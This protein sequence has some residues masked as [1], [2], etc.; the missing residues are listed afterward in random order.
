[1]QPNTNLKKLIC[2]SNSTMKTKNV[3][4]KLIICILWLAKPLTAEAIPIF[5][6]ADL[7]DMLNQSTTNRMLFNRYFGHKNFKS[8][9]RLLNIFGL[10]L[11][12]VYSANIVSPHGE[13]NCTPA[14][15]PE[16]EHLEYLY[17][18][19]K[20]GE[21]VLVQGTINGV[22]F[23]T[24]MLTP[25]QVWRLPSS[26]DLIPDA[27][28]G[29]PQAQYQLGEVYTYGVGLP[30]DIKLGTEW[31]ERAAKQ[32]HAQATVALKMLSERQ[33]LGVYKAEQD[34]LAD[35]ARQEK[36]RIAAYAAA[37]VDQLY[38]TVNDGDS[39]AQMNL[40]QRYLGG[41]GV[42][43]NESL[44]ID[45]LS[46]AVSQG[47]TRALVA[48]KYAATPG[49]MFNGNAEA[50]FVLGHL[51]AAGQGVIASDEQA[52]E[53]FNLAAKQNYPGAKDAV[54]LY[55]TKVF[56]TLTK[57]AVKGDPQA[58]LKLAKRYL[59]QSNESPNQNLTQAIPLLIRAAGMGNNEALEILQL[60][61]QSTWFKQGDPHA[62]FAL[63]EIFFQGIGAVADTAKASYW[64]DIAASQ[65]IIDAK[66]RI[67]EIQKQTSK[68]S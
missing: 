7:S 65:G 20:A 2:L 24:L 5:T 56:E 27:E 42:T 60:Q 50:A 47:N 23:G 1:M 45:Y 41:S 66:N 55:D 58:C 4:L 51:Y 8:S 54:K 37:S 33:E 30:S 64:Y 13:I 14:V 61:A 63:G 26:T 22:A 49:I 12:N 48:L 57:A 34:R 40:G 6:G 25:C 32:G 9:G 35:A 68:K 39:E 19:Y 17:D 3:N 31:Y 59:E 15:G 10:S 43:K 62:A 29:D 11:L 52:L 53:W 44:G 38:K 18:V 28:R 36:A 46:K 67:I 16:M 21:P